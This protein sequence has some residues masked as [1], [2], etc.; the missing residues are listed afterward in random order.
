[1]AACF[2][3]T[4]PI[5]W[6]TL[7]PV[8][9]DGATFGSADCQCRFTYSSKGAKSKHPGGANMLLRRR[10]GPVPQE[11]DQSSDL[12][13]DRQPGWRRGR[14]LRRLLIA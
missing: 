6:M 7:R 2:G 13:C 9:S 8:R 3:T 1:M 14:Q 4:V 11:L 10:F 5:N 12:L